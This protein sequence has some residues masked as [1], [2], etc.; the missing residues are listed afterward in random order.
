MKAELILKCVMAP[1]EP[2]RTFV[3]NYIRLMNDN[4]VNTFKMTLEMKGYTKKTDINNFIEIF[5]AKIP[6]MQQGA[7]SPSSTV[8]GSLLLNK[9]DEQ[10]AKTK[11]F[12]KIQDL[13]RKKL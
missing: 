7:T 6:N 8:N 3:D 4:D 5:K 10:D 1:G 9:S 13:I 12:D 2:A 11:Q